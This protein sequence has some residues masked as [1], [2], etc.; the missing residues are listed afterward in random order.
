MTA[1]GKG[2][3]KLSGAGVKPV[4]KAVAKAATYRVK[5]TL[6]GAAKRALKKSGQVRKKV[7]VTFT[8]R[9]GKASSV[10]LQVTYKAAATRKGN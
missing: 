9:E 1:P 2:R 6:T 8:P 4:S 10:T 3:L 7:K 5:A